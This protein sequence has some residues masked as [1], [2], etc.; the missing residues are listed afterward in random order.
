MNKYSLDISSAER[1]RIAC[2]VAEGMKHLATMRVRY[3]FF[4]TLYIVC[5]MSRS[6]GLVIPTNSNT[7]SDWRRICHV[8]WM[9]TIKETT[10]WTFDVH[11]IRS[12]SLKPRK[13]VVPP[14]CKQMSNFSHIFELGGIT[15]HLWL[16]P[17]GNSEFCSISTLMFS[18]EDPEETKLIVALQWKAFCTPL[19]KCGALSKVAPNCH[20]V[21]R[22]RGTARGELEGILQYGSYVLP[23][24]SEFSTSRAIKEIGCWY[25]KEGGSHSL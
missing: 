25:F 2:D 3:K 9:T 17:Q 6:K 13:F 16:A 1:L 22:G 4:H 19:S 8:S 18:V 20:G 23:R 5:N 15:K 7:F 14:G 12:C 24:F 21:E 11:V 10:T